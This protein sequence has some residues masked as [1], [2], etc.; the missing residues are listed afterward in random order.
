MTGGATRRRGYAGRSPSSD[1]R[2]K[3]KHG[4][5]L[6]HLTRGPFF[7]LL[8]LWSCATE[9]Q[10]DPFGHGAGTGAGSGQVGSAVSRIGSAWAR[11]GA[12]HPFPWQ[13][14][15][16]CP[17]GIKMHAHHGAEG[18]RREPRSR[19]GFWP[20]RSIIVR[21]GSPVSTTKGR[22]R[23]DE[24]RKGTRRRPRR[25]RR[26]VALAGSVS[27]E[28]WVWHQHPSANPTCHFWPWGASLLVWHSALVGL[29]GKHGCQ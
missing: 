24:N 27:V 16:R 10:E 28:S 17:S 9:G 12:G 6:N 19:D 3:A 25:R 4:S 23:H 1:A 2:G 21:L 8:S 15:S 5:R 22:P 11:P 20:R 14:G 7:F 26:D 13:L 18:R 29:R